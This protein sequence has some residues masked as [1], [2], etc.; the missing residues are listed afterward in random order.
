MRSHLARIVFDAMD[1]RRFTPAEDRQADGVHPWRIDDAA[2]VPDE[3]LLVQHWYV[4]PAVIGMEPGRP[5]D[6]RHLAVAQIDL[7][8]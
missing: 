3:P 6:G 5:D 2:L 4:Q 1:E 8:W 7:Q